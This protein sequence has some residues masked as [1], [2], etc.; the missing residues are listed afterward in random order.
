MESFFDIGEGLLNEQTQG[1]LNMKFTVSGAIFLSGLAVS[2]IASSQDL[3]ANK[4]V[5]VIMA[6]HG[7]IDDLSELRDY[8]LTAVRK[9][10]GLQVP[11]FLRPLIGQIGFPLIRGTFIDQYTSLGVSTNYRKY[12]QEQA[13]ALTAELRSRGLNGQAYVGFNFLPPFADEVVA[14]LS[15]EGYTDIVVLNRGAQYS[16]ATSEENFEDVRKGIKAA[17]NWDV[18]ALG[19][20][21]WSDRSD[22]RD[23]METVLR[24]DVETFFPGVEK[25]D[26]CIGLG[27]HGLPLPLIKQGDPA[28]EQMLSVVEDLRKRMPEFPIY[29]GFLNDDFFP[30]VAWIEPTFADVAFD[31]ARD[32]CP[33][34]LLDGRLSFTVHHRATLFDMDV[35]AR[36]TISKFYPDAQIAFASNFNGDPLLAEV[37]ANV[38]V[39][40]LETGDSDPNVVDLKD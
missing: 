32:L 23:L 4:K 26:V 16:I 22:F 20:K 38:V 36:E 10:S 27:S 13:D 2:S 25:K 30:G 3:F 40:A 31:M 11:D 29:H 15:D 6:S 17:G 8:S 1:D 33:Y 5:A 28:T 34:V 14:E 35:D 18:R 37:L 19:V 39:D 7:D 9:N 12:S 24:R 21:Q